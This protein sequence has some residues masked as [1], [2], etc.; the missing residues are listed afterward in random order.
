MKSTIFSILISLTIIGG[1]FV[2]SR[3]NSERDFNGRNSGNNV[4]V[5]DGV[6]I[7]EISARGGYL[8]QI[9]NA[10]AGLPTIVRFD[11]RNTF[12][13]SALV[14]IPSLGVN[15]MLPQ[16]GKTDIDVGVS[17]GGILQGS[18]GMGMYP[19]EINFKS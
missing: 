2:L 14:S 16:T 6:Q 7:I 17:K 19:F 13:C 8:P 4:R 12:D 11:T 18:C 10:K 3:G 9:S 1:A 5:V 15:K